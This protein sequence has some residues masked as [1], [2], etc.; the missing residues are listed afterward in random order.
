MAAVGRRG[1]ALNFG[2]YVGHTAV[3]L[4]V[5]GEDAYERAATDTELARMQA[6]VAD[7]IEGGAIGFA[8][9]ASPTHN[10]DHGRPVPSRVAGLDELRAPDRAP[11]AGPTG[12][13]WPSLPGGAMTHDD[14]FDLQRA[15]GRPITWT[16]LLTVKGYPYHTKVI[17][18]NDA[19]RAEGVEGLGPR[20]PAARWCS[21]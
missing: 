9:S 2:C 16:A 4:Y 18:K 8:S 7:A 1:T 11:C 10:G 13:W 17:E 21:R 6:V 15:V 5:M 14:V 3:R 19:A 20:C 12:A